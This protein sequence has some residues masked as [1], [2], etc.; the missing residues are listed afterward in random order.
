[1]HPAIAFALFTVTAVAEI[2]GCWL[3]LRW[4]QGTAAGWWALPAAAASLAVF[5]W[6][7]TQHPH[8][9][10]RIYAAYGGIYVL[11]SLLWLLGV[12]RAPLTRFDLIGTALCVVGS[13]VIYFQPTRIGSS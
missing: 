4:W 2:L 11:V 10:G 3:I 7:L 6:L 12:D 5:A 13:C 1:M 8:A 9:A